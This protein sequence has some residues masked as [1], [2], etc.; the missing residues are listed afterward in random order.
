MNHISLEAQEETLSL[1]QKL[2]LKGRTE[3][4]IPVATEL[5]K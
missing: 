4:I 2:I 3:A 5:K 1:A